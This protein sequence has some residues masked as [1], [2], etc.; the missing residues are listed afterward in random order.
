MTDISCF[1]LGLMG[2]ALVRSLIKGGHRVSVWNRTPAKTQPLVELG[3]SH[4]TS[5]AAALE[6]SP[7]SLVCVDSYQTTRSMFDARDVVGKL[8]G[9]VI[10]QLSTGT[11]K[12]ARDGEVWFTSHD[13]RYLDGAILGGPASIGTPRVTILYSGRQETFERCKG[14]LGALGEDSRFV[15]EKV[16]SAAA[17]DLAWL[18]K[19]YGA[20]CGVAHGTILCEAE[21]VDLG[22]YSAVFAESDNARWMIDV[23]KKNAFANPRATLSVWN[24]GLRHIIDQAR[25]ANINSEVPDFVA[26][27]LD[28]AEAA[29]YGEEDIA[30]MVKVVRSPPLTLSLRSPSVS[31][32][33]LGREK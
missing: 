31:E 3:A 20:F 1:G 23:V 12:E 6:A 13:A 22:L 26:S 18:S 4:A 5:V 28:R 27:I 11:P 24:A 33:K 2:S 16:G 32:S 15:G 29:G 30:A 9:R 19:L 8:A 10:V 14:L 21:G 7:I 25:D 17:L